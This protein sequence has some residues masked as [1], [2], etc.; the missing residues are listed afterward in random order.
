ML[1]LTGEMRTPTQRPDFKQLY[2]TVVLQNAASQLNLVKTHRV[3]GSRLRRRCYEGSRYLR[4]A[5]EAS[6]FGP[7]GSRSVSDCTAFAVVGKA[8]GGVG[9]K[10]LARQRAAESIL[11][12]AA[13]RKQEVEERAVAKEQA[14]AN[15]LGKIRGQEEADRATLEV[16]L[17]AC[18]C[19][20]GWLD[21]CTPAIPSPSAKRSRATA[22]PINGRAGYVLCVVKYPRTCRYPPCPLL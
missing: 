5:G 15:V 3:F 22:Q 6:R 4:L 11:S 14:T 18:L 21:A 2:S 16:C 8:G 17:S 10:R 1:E 7:F 20:P 13:A 9:A 12:A 19:V